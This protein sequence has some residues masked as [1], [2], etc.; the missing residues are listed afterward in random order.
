MGMRAP[1]NQATQGWTPWIVTLGLWSENSLFHL[2]DI[3]VVLSLVSPGV[4]G[5]HTRLT[6][7]V[8][9]QSDCVCGLLVSSHGSESSVSRGCF[10][11]V[12]LSLNTGWG[13][14]E[15]S[16]LHCSSASLL[17]SVRTVPCRRQVIPT[18]GLRLHFP[19]S[20]TMLQHCGSYGQNKHRP[21]EL[22]R[23]REQ[24]LSS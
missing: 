7:S 17:I 11:T 20:P 5:S 4:V 9:S 24:G 21:M 16:T 14:Q 12:Q 22:M 15:V 18:S 2:W 19:W 1:E 13:S 6:S 3:S 8:S 10:L 23:G